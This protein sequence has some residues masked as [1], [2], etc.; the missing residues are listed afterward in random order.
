MNSTTPSV[1]RVY[2][3]VAWIYDLME[4]PMDWMGGAE[5]RRRV[6]GG[7]RGRVLEVGVG[8]G[9]NLE[10][11]PDGVELH[12]IDISAQMLRRAR[13]RAERTGRSVT[14]EHADAEAL[15][16]ADASFDT[17]T[18]TCVFCSVGDPVRG[19]QEVGRVVKP[20]GRVLLLEHVRP[21]N[22]VL[23][24][25]FDLLTPITRRLVGPE[26]N[27]RT[28]NNVRRAGLE[29]IQVRREGIW[30]EIEARP[31]RPA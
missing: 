25:L 16:F 1:A 11:Y 21:E 10:H 9:A 22:P 3:R 31:L 6:L 20:E 19:L 7:A 29:I 23:G 8:T 12:G 2:D 30:R 17:V 27:R 15:P 13:D 14:L 24:K 5:R 4:A 26:I 28:E 18:A